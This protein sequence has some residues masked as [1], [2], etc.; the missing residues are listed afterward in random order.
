MVADVKA[1]HNNEWVSTRRWR[2]AKAA[3]INLPPD[4]HACLLRW[5]VA[6]SYNR[7]DP[8]PGQKVTQRMVMR[9]AT[10]VVA[11]FGIDMMAPPDKSLEEDQDY[12]AALDAIRRLG[13][14]ERRSFIEWLVKAKHPDDRALRADAMALV[15]NLR[16]MEKQHRANLSGWREGGGRRAPRK[17]RWGKGKAR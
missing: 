12:A 3:A 8:Q 7:F 2:E 9:F 1:K 14:G 4:R 16:V 6:S 11:K 17:R 10:A 15:M 5:C 13:D